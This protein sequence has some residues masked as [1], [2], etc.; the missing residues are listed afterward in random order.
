VYTYYIS[1]I[2]T[3]YSVIR[4]SGKWFHMW[5]N[6]WGFGSFG[7]TLLDYNTTNPPCNAVWIF[8]SSDTWTNGSV[9]N[10]S[11][12]PVAPARHVPYYVTVTGTTCFTTQESQFT[13]IEP[14]FI[15]FPQ[16]SNL[17]SAISQSEMGKMYFD[18]STQ[19]FQINDGYAR[20]SIW[21]NYEH[22]KIND[23]QKLAFGST[24][25]IF[26]TPANNSGGDVSF[27]LRANKIV[28]SDFSGNNMI[29]TDAS[30]SPLQV[31]F[32]KSIGVNM[33]VVGVSTTLNSSDHIVVYSGS[34]SDTFTLPAIPY[35]SVGLEYIIVNQGSS[36]LTISPALKNGFSTTLNQLPEG[37]SITIVAGDSGVW[38]L[39]SKSQL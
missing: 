25:E 8:G 20:K 22:Y 17:T 10:P 39:I 27:N 36:S 13:T 34:G 1:N 4:Y 23:A 33:R 2:S 24:A 30:T 32:N 6:P 35:F 18:K 11:L 29:S 15:Q 5:S 9:S 28:L 31:K 16:M 19:S 26:S 3:T 37:Y 12:I 14:T 38:R 7:R 21:P